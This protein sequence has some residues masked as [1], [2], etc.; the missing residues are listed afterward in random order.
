MYVPS[1]VL[2]TG[3]LG[4]IGSH[5]CVN[6][7]LKYPQSFF[8]GIDKETYCSNS[9]NIDEIRHHPNFIYI[10]TDLTDQISVESLFKE[11]SIDT[12][13]HFAAYSHVD[14]SFT[15]SI[16]FT[17]NNILG[18]HILIDVAY[19]HQV[20]RFI[21]MSTDEVYGGKDDCMNED[22]TL[23]PTNPYAASKAGAE[24]IVKS[25]YHSFKVPIIIIRSNNVYG[26]KQYPEKV[27]PKFC[28]RLMRGLPCILQGSGDQKRS[29]IYID[30]FIRGFEL[31]W[32][33]GIVGQT[34][35]IGSNDEIAIYQLAVQIIQLIHPSI[36]SPNEYLR[37][38]D[39]RKFNDIRYNISNTKLSSLG[40]SP[41]IP[42]DQGLKKTVEWYMG[43]GG[44]WGEDELKNIL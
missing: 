39:D 38:G 20:K 1:V 34:Y 29:F 15:N 13:L 18:T 14:L 17:E 21:H 36:V 30:D 31:I 26:P 9:K 40:W 8:I 5:V 42:F 11:Y 12:V 27:I 3:V 41:T 43:N 2:I 10:K 6:L 28:V 33:S 16:L 24:Q 37:F 35:N 25:Y 4:F 23:D 7:V 32:L 44:Y 19:R 22:C